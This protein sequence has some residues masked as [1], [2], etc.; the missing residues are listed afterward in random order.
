MGLWSPDKSLVGTP[1]CCG[2]GGACPAALLPVSLY[3]RALARS[4]SSLFMVFLDLFLWLFSRWSAVWW[5]EEV[6]QS[7]CRICPTQGARTVLAG[8]EFIPP[9][10]HRWSFLTLQATRTLTFDIFY[11]SK[12]NIKSAFTSSSV[13]SRGITAAA[14]GKG[15]VCSIPPARRLQAALARLLVDVWSTSV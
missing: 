7:C 2:K 10:L 4:V 3:F 5:Q 1:H 8:A 9:S 15:S 11:M 6:L 14:V 12:G 13:F